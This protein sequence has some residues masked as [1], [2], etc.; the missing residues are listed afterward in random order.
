MRLMIYLRARYHEAR[1]ARATSRGDVAGAY[2]HARLSEKF[3]A[4]LSS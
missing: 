3:F 2:H 4:R 1:S